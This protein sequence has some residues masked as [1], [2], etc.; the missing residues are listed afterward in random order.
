MAYT[1]SKDDQVDM[2]KS[3]LEKSLI[4]KVGGWK[5]EQEKVEIEQ[6][7]L[8]FATIVNMKKMAANRRMSK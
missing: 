3:I 8:E 4:R 5:Q 6:R 7:K 2:M 1:G